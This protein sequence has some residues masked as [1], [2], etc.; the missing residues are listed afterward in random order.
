L[1]GLTDAVSDE[2][3]LEPRVVTFC[4]ELGVP[5]Y[6][7]EVLRAW[8]HAADARG[9]AP[10][11]ETTLPP[12]VETLAP[13]V[14]PS[15]FWGNSLDTEPPSMEGG[16]ASPPGPLPE[17]YALEGALGAGGMG[18]V[19]LVRDRLLGRAVAFKRL[20][21]ALSGRAD[22]LQRFVEEA[23]VTAQLEHP[24]ILPLYDLGQ[25]ADGQWY[26]TTPIVRGHTLAEVI[27]RAHDSGPLDPP[28]LRHL[29]GLFHRACEAVAY[30]H[31]QGV[32][33]RDIKPLNIMV[34]DHG[35]VTVLDWGLAKLLHSPSTVGTDQ[36]SVSVEHPRTGTMAT[37]EG[38]VA[39]TPAY[40]APEQ[41]RGE[42][43]RLDTRSDVYALGAVLLELLGG[44]APFQAGA[45]E[46]DLS[47]IRS[48]G[49]P[50]TLLAICSRAL[51][52]EMA[53]RFPDAGAM[54]LAVGD[55]LE[56]VQRRQRA[57]AVVDE[58]RA[59]EDEAE[60]LRR[61]ARGRWDDADAA[62][63]AEGVESTAGWTA[64]EEAG[65]LQ[66]AATLRAQDAE[67]LLQGALVHDPELPEAHR[68]LARR[69]RD[70]RDRATR[71]GDS[72]AAERVT[73][74]LTAHLEWLPRAEQRAL[75]GPAAENEIVS[76]RTRLGP[77]VGRRRLHAA[78][79]DQLA[80]GER[81]G[82]PRLLTLVGTAGAGKT[83]LALEVAADH[84]VAE[85]PAV[86]VFCDLTE[87]RTR[88]GV[89]HL[90]GQALSVP[91]MSQDPETQLGYALRAR[92]PLLLVL[93]NLEQ[94]TADVATLLARWFSMAPA[95][96]VLGTSRS[97]LGVAAE[98]AVEV[99]PLTLLEAMKLFL[100][101]GQRANPGFRLRPADR[102]QVSELVQQL[103]RLPLA[104]ELAAARLS[105][106]SL[107]EINRRLNERFQLLRSRLRAPEKR[108]LQGALEW[109]W[110]LL[111]ASARS[112]L[113]QVSVF[114]GGFDLVA[115]EAV[116]DLSDHPGSPGVLDVLEALVDD[117]LL[118][119][120]GGARARAGGEVP[121]RYGLFESIRHFADHK[122]TPG[123]EA[124]A[125]A[126]HA[127]YF[128]AMGRPDALAA[129][130]VHEGGR[131]R[132]RLHRELDNLVVAAQRADGDPAGGCC[133]AAMAVMDLT[134]PLSAG[135]DL[136]E[137][138]LERGTLSA[139]VRRRL[140]QLQGSLLRSAGKG[141]V[142]EAQ[143]EAALR[144]HREAADRS[145][146]GIVQG[147]LGGLHRQQGRMDTAL[148]HY[149]MALTIHREV[150]NRRSE[151]SVLGSLGILHMQQSRIDTARVHY[152]RALD[153]HQEVGNRRG[154]G[155]VLGSLGTLHKEQGRTATA[156]VHYERALD[157]HREV[158]DRR[159]EGIVQGN[160]G[161]LHVHQGR[162]DTARVHYEKALDIHR[163]VGNRRHEGFVLCN[164]GSL[165]REQGRM[166]TARVHYER[167]LHISRALGTQ[168]LE[169]SALSNLGA[170]ASS[171]GEW[172]LA[173]ASFER[174]EAL[175]RELDEEHELG[176]LLCAR[177]H[178]HL[179]QD[180]LPEAT[181]ALAEA[182]ALARATGASAES[183]LGRALAVL[184]EELATP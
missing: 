34:G 11:P 57:L 17:R 58:A 10:A 148:K 22:L 35:A 68:A 6:I 168:R 137:E 120:R 147:N 28:A 179:R 67:Q 112:V 39:G 141:E 182:T 86:V 81:P 64:W 131:L 8:A 26:Y 69:L 75:G 40:M 184:R 139:S 173:A 143:L 153:I 123:G 181:D 158:G 110:E 19:L 51:A 150:G 145:G 100:H 180:H 177:G 37:W 117:H 101:R 124:T 56:G 166:D 129:L 115:A 135:A 52:L 45:P 167:A 46:D 54:A 95:L 176:K 70:A 21:A 23:Q 170:L 32:L 82:R 126:R 41:A 25:L 92:G 55:W 20:H 146:E 16:S 43:D 174:G 27:R 122:P 151:G 160:L 171:R 73:R 103:D 125:V 114:R 99:G 175:L 30:A 66:Q 31:A 12:S 109:S 48:R 93:D 113:S 128:G 36:K 80:D 102:V 155:L 159:G 88:A 178:L 133:L 161:I 121:V 111:S 83:R 3:D 127:V 136:A 105:M 96:Q 90:V 44:P 107:P 76:L 85:R 50:E 78:L 53:D 118:R 154:E 14:F 149:E 74:R 13:G 7:Q 5:R 24:G 144:V 183:E 65:R 132:R 98:H 38:Q 106:L 61:Q 1:K 4:Q 163:E 97:R 71:A 9:D 60:A 42:I 157:I 84:V 94:V 2:R 87:A 63:S 33:H 116:V 164:L 62:L 130:D 152:E 47:A 108:A 91:L 134:G 156:R 59:A 29:V 15:D 172:A 119:K 79:S 49:C 72:A 89:L 104:I 140:L 138:L 169:G 162:I 142:A 165:H 77:F 18:S